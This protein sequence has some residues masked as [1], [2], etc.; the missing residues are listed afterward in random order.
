MYA[1]RSYYVVH[2]VDQYQMHRDRK[3]YGSYHMNVFNSRTLPRMHQW[4]LSPE[5]EQ[6][7][8]LQLSYNFV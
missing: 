2:T 4:T 3:V 6:N 8:L 7:E 5:L 1:I